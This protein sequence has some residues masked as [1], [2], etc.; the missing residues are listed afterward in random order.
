VGVPTE[1]TVAFW[2]LRATAAAAA[3]LSWGVVLARVMGA[4]CPTDVDSSWPVLSVT[5]TKSPP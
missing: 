5:T 4:C 1:S 2:A 3:A